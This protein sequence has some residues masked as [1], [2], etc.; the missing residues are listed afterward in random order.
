VFSSNTI[1][2][3]DPNN[4][5]AGASTACIRIQNQATTSVASNNSFVDNHIDP[6]VYGQFIVYNQTAGD[7]NN[8]FDGNLVQQSAVTEDFYISPT[9]NAQVIQQIA[10]NVLGY[11]NSVDGVNN[12]T[13][14]LV[15]LNAE[16]F[17][18]NSE[19]S[20]STYTWTCKTP[21]Y[22]RFTGQVGLTSSNGIQVKLR[23]N[24]VD[25]AYSLPPVGASASNQTASIATIAYADIGDVFDLYVYHSTGVAVVLT[26]GAATTFLCVS[27]T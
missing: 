1:E 4:L 24:A 25:Y 2:N 27:K 9:L 16:L 20:T 13:Y 18:T 14:K 7:I 5:H 22:Y 19:F 11:A 10:T 17:D 8:R 15:Q 3:I 21:G 6:G 26:T 12:A 23:K